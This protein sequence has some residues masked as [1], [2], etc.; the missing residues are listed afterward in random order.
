MIRVLQVLGSLQRGGAET[1]VMNVY[2]RMDRSRVQFDF[3][4][5]DRVD[6]G[7]E[8]EA[9]GYGARIL[10]VR[11]AKELGIAPYVRQLKFAI[12]ENGPYPIVHSHV[13][14][15]SGLIL[16]AAKSAGVP[17]RISHSHSTRY[18]GGLQTP[19]GKTLISLFATM[20]LACGAEAGK[21]LFGHAPFEIVQNGIDD[22]RFL[23]LP[24]IGDPNLGG[25]CHIGRFLPVKNQTFIV[26]VCRLLRERGLEPR[27]TLLGDGDMR[28][29]IENSAKNMLPNLAFPGS[30]ADPERFLAES[31]MFILPSLYEGLPLTAVEAQCAGR[32]CLLSDHVSSDVDLGLGLVRFLPLEVGA[33]V[34]AISEL[35]AGNTYPV[36]DENAIAGALADRGYSASATAEKIQGMYEEMARWVRT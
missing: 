1:M 26:D 12:H 24:Y 7:Y 18:P 23:G 10:H 5:K 2:R 30:V 8:E 27:V 11:S 21:A 3:L 9:V 15:L 16:F 29:Q 33:W 19:I 20:R 32:L 34:T 17:N 28:R 22:D 36:V 14:N 6:N 35:L 31:R 13:N 4:V 25:I